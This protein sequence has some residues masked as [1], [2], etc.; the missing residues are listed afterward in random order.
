M[1]TG[2]FGGTFNPIHNGHLLNARYIRE[3]F[4][5]DRILFVPAGEPVH[6]KLAGNVDKELRCEMVSL[7]I[8]AEEGFEVSRI[9]LDRQEPSYTIITLRELAE[10]FPGDEFFLI[11]GADSF[12]DLDSWKESESIMNSVPVIVMR[13]PG[14]PDL[15]ESVAEKI[16]TLLVSGNNNI[17]ISSSLI[18]NR[19]AEGLPVDHLVPSAVDEFIRS[20]RLYQS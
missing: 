11:I 14:D 10:K 1:K 7:A 20:R 8:A 3:E 6:K 16:E 2:I 19:V 12:N 18:R 13:R 17:D 15:R 4:R 5:L 9:E